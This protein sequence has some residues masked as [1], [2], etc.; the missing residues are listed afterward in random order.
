[1]FEAQRSEERVVEHMWYEDGG[2]GEAVRTGQGKE[3]R[4]EV[5]VREAGVADE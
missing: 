2:I 5:G 4:E 3:V 1:M